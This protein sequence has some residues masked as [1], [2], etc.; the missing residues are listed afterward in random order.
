MIDFFSG[1]LPQEIDGA[2][3]PVTQT[4]GGCGQQLGTRSP[5]D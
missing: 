2:D 5:G 4:R 3:V 1:Q